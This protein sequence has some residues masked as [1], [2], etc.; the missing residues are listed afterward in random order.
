MA[1]DAVIEARERIAVRCTD[2]KAKIFG[3]DKDLQALGEALTQLRRDQAYIAECM[4]HMC[5]LVHGLLFE[6]REPVSWDDP[7]LRMLVDWQE[8]LRKI[9]GLP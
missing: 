1:S 6:A 7:T 8:R 3:I 9:A 4:A 2:P 5:P